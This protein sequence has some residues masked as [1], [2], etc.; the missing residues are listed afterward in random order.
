MAS[1]F[2]VPKFDVAKAE[3]LAVRFRLRV[4][5]GSHVHADHAARLADGFRRDENIV[6]RARSE[7]QDHLAR[8][9]PRKGRWKAATEIQI[10]LRRVSFDALVRFRDASRQF[11][12]PAT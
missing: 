2:P 4:H 5:L 1:D 7:I 12:S 10:G 11:R 3:L 8:A 6:A 9:K